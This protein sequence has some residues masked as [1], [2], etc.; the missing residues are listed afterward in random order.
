MCEKVWCH[1]EAEAGRLVAECREKKAAQK[2]ARERSGLTP[3]DQ[4]VETSDARYAAIYETIA[5]TPATNLAGLAVKVRRLAYSVEAGGTE[6]DDTL[7]RTLLEDVERL[8]GEG[9]AS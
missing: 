9:G 6:W 2:A 3:L 5:A 7:V 1:R 4:A 8:A